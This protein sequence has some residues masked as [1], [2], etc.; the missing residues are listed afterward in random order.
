M[1]TFRVYCDKSRIGLMITLAGLP[2]DRL[3]KV[4]TTKGAD[5]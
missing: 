5:I 1:D 2:I 4:F 3:K